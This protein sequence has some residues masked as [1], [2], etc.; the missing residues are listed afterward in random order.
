MT[1]L[2]GDESG[3]VLQNSTA[4]RAESILL[5][6]RK[7]SVSAVSSDRVSLRNVALPTCDGPVRHRLLAELSRATFSFDCAGELPK[8]CVNVRTSKLDEFEL[9]LKDTTTLQA[10]ELVDVTASLQRAIA[11]QTEEGH[12]PEN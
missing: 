3:C 7:R 8:I 9:H 5:S 1:Y 11:V 12:A 6:A 2:F 4:S 10:D